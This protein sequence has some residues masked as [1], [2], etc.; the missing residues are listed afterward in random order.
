[1]WSSDLFQEVERAREVKFVK[2]DDY[3][4]SNYIMTIKCKLSNI[5]LVYGGQKKNIKRLYIHQ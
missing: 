4:C 3:K 1:M 5:F 2:S